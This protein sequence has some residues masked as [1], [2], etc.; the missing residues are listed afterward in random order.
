MFSKLA[1]V[2]AGIAFL[3]GVAN[4]DRYLT[5]IEELI[6]QVKRDTDGK[7]HISWK[8]TLTQKMKHSNEFCD[9]IKHELLI[10]RLGNHYSYHDSLVAID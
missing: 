5:E 8:E 6:M 3:G 1:K 4:A 9:T 10:P 7:E 2:S